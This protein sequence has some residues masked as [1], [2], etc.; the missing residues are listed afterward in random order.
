MPFGLASVRPRHP[1]PMIIMTGSTNGTGIA[2]IS[3]VI[4]DCAA[5][6]GIGAPCDHNDPV[7]A[8][9]SRSPVPSIDERNADRHVKASRH[10]RGHTRDQSDFNEVQ[11]YLHSVRVNFG[12]CCDGV[13]NSTE[14]Q[15]RGLRILCRRDCGASNIRDP[16]SGE[17]LQKFE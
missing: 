12:Y 9:S 16:V 14:R 15:T 4:S 3:P 11:K 7:V 13:T 1:V 17:N 8:A 6:R 5:R 10:D 2:R